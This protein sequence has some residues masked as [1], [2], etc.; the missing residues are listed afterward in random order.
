MY[1]QLMVLG[2]TATGA[3]TPD[4]AIVS[5]TPLA[6]SMVENYARLL[7][8]VPIVV[9]LLFVA[10]LSLIIAIKWWRFSH[11]QK[12]ADAEARAAALRPDGLPYP[13]AGRGMCEA[14][15]RAFDKVYFMP[16]G[17]RLCPDCY[18]SS[19]MPQDQP[20]AAEGSCQ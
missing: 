3:S 1:T 2:Y 10:V 16:N 4:A 17:R 7:V 19:E 5:E 20:A 18:H 12:R 8:I 15:T 14:C 11:R 9:A 6:M 13:P